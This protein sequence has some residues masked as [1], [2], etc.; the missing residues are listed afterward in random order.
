MCSIAD[1]CH[2]W[3]HKWSGSRNIV[4]LH[5]VGILEQGVITWRR[6]HQH[7]KKQIF[8]H[9]F[10]ILESNPRSECLS[11]SELWTP[12]ASR[13]L[14]STLFF[15]IIIFMGSSKTWCKCSWICFHFATI[16]EWVQQSFVRNNVSACF[17]KHVYHNTR[18]NI[19]ANEGLLYSFLATRA[20]GCTQP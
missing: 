17:I 6:Q 11:D 2:L 19:F 10:T 14:W 9:S 7:R 15:P 4:G 12:K 8:I 13:P 20:T 5:L 16:N 1:Q 3:P 18:W